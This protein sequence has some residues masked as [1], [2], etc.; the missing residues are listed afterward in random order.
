MAEIKTILALFL[1]N[2]TT[3]FS[4]F[5]TVNQAAGAE[6]N[7]NVSIWSILRDLPF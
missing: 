6:D 1:V 2:Q 7:K 3:P 4:S 5:V